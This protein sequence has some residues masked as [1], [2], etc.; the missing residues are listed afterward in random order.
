MKKTFTINISG[1]VFHID[2]DA[3]ERLNYYILQI[4]RHFGNDADAKEIVQDIESRISELFQERVKDGSEVITIEQVEE[5]IKI[6][7]MPEAFADSKDENEQVVTK[8]SRSRTKKLYRDPDD[9]I[10]GGVCSGL[11]AYFNIDPIIVRLIF[12]ALFFGG[13]SSLI[14]YL[15]LWII[16]PKAANTAQRLEMKG[17]EVN[18]NNISKTIKEEI[19]DVKENYQNFRASKSYIRSRERIDDAGNVALSVLRAIFKIIV[20]FFGIILVS[21]GIIAII[22]LFTSLFVSSEFIGITPF[23]NELPHYLGLFVSDGTLT[24]FWIGLALTLGIPLIMLAYLGTKLIFRFES[25]NPAIG[26]SSLG[27]WVLGIILLIF[28]SVHGVSDFKSV[29]TSTKQEPVFTKSDTLYLKLGADEFSDYLDSNFDLDGL[30]IA[31]VN[32]KQFLLNEP[33][34]EIEKSETNEFS[35]VVKS[36]ARGR[37]LDIA[38][39]NARNINYKFEQKDSLLTFQPWFMLPDKSVWH[40]QEI[41]IVLKVPENKTIYLSDEMVKIIHDI[42]NTSNMWDGDMVGKYWTMTPDGLELTQ[43]KAAPVETSKKLKK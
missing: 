30:R 31:S 19:Q 6:M 23:S 20:V 24:W 15:I 27:L 18:I 4:N 3:Y 39:T 37:D 42:K 13:G 40:K 10:L 22:A 38:Q 1:T 12:V 11:A 28:A 29:S 33:Q 32:G 36:K 8:I 17:E 25:N 43:R 35:V 7:G 21:I 34:L 9:R 5:I 26:F 41:D 14:I 16:A 2:D